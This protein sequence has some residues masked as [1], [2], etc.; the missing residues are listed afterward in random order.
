MSL[1]ADL[2]KTVTDT[3]PVLAAVG[4]TDLAVE[5]ARTFGV[6]ARS[7]RVD[8]DPAKLQ[9]K[10]QARA[11]ELA[12]TARELPAHALNRGLEIAGEA[13]KSYEELA[14]RGKD[15][16]TRVRTQKATQDLLKQASSTVS[17]G[18]GAV[19]TVRRSA[20]DIQR[21]ALATI[22]TGRKEA[23]VAAD[24]IIDSVTEEAEEATTAVT[25]AAKRTRTAA[26]RT[27]TTTKKSAASTKRATKGTVTSARKTTARARK[28]TTT[29]SA[30]VG[31]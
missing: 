19:T 10:A 5:K 2:R 12:D 20:T 23:S 28:A 21:S 18:K 3:T 31:D 30:K 17:L 4:A 8:V 13:Q 25:A 22:T 26:K 9:V 16:V 1:I 29:A 7:A 11:A 15:L 6:K 14:V 24:A 27:S